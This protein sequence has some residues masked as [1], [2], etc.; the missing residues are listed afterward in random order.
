MRADFFTGLVVPLLGHLAL[1]YEVQT[2]PLDTDWTYKVGT[3][4]WPEHPRPQLQRDNWQSL[5]GIWKW[6]AA[7]G[8]G[9]APPVGE[10]LTQDV[11][12]PSCLESGL[13]GVQQLNVV[14]A[15]FTTEFEL[16][17]KWSNSTGR[18]LLNFEA[19]DYEATVYI[20]GQ[21][22]GF[23]RGGYWRFTVDATKFL[24]SGVNTL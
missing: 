5:N 19:V 2:P 24:K 7:A 10:D 21:E 4:P 18:V 13:S 6:R 14:Y 11:L 15:W 9:E 23:N 8:P 1:G 17:Q 3:D 20:N 16:P 22:A 12:V